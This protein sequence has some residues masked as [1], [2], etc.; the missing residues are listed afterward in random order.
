MVVSSSPVKNSMCGG[1]DI[2]AVI[3]F[4]PCDS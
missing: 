1:F 2:F 3:L 4:V